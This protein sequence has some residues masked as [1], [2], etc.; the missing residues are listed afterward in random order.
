[1]NAVC[2]KCN[3]VLTEVGNYIICGTCGYKAKNNQHESK[4]KNIQGNLN[5]NGN[6]RKFCGIIFKKKQS[7]SYRQYKHLQILRQENA[8]GTSQ[9]VLLG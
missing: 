2:P 1:M 5:C 4:R 3:N 6:K 7:L 8:V 9:K